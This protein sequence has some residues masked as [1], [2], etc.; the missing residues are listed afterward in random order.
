MGRCSH[1]LS[2]DAAIMVSGGCPIIGEHVV[3][4]SW[5][6]GL[7]WRQCG[8]KTPLIAALGAYDSEAAW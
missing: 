1:S 2:L 5:H 3:I 6:G 7:P 8:L 4:I